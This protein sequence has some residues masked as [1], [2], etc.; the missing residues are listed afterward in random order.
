MKLARLFWKILKNEFG[1]IGLAAGIL[2][3]SS[4]LGSLFGGNDEEVV[5]PYADLRGKYQD[6]L[7]GKLGTSTPYTQNSAFNLDKPA[8]ETAAEKSILGY[9][10]K[11]TSNVSDYTEATKKYSDAT[12]A[13]MEETN[14]REMKDTQD[15]YNRL[16]LVSSTP[17]LTAQGDLLKSQ[18]NTQDLFDSEL[19]YKN[20]DRQLSAQGLDVSQLD[21]MLSQASVLGQGQTAR[22]EYSQKMSMQ[23]IL[24]QIAEMQ[25]YSGQAEGLLSSNP[26]TTIQT[27]NI[28]SNLGNTGQDVGSLL[29]MSSILGK[30]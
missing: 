5:D 12:R 14:S 20:L 17:G 28:W 2:G 24:N 21:S 10:N 8:V 4:L 7:K 13:S 18:R 25:G 29:L 19:M 1:G 16:G 23:D 30:K 6:Y 22:Q 27:P 9:F 26:P 15:M 3:G 11:P